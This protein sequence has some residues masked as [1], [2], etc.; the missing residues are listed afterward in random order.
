MPDIFHNFTIAARRGAV[1]EAITT[2]K[3]LDEWW[4]KSSSGDP[5]SGAI[6]ELDF[7]PGFSWRARVTQVVPNEAFELQLIQADDDW[8]DTRIRFDL[9][10]N[11]GITAVR[12]R[13]LG[14]Q[15][16]NDVYR[17]SCYC[18]AAYFRILRRYLEHGERVPYERRLDA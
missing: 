10:T 15:S 16:T 11:S 7:G 5:R 14:W 9:T 2:P 8:T 13:H 12:F 6:Y 18:W 17:V 3:G 4:T 1:F